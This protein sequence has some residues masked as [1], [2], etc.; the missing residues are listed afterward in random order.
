[1]GRKS[2]LGASLFLGERNDFGKDLF[3]ERKTEF[4]SV[5]NMVAGKQHVVKEG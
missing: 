1:L 5:H 2:I 3:L 4:W